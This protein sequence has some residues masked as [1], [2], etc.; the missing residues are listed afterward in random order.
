M[1]QEKRSTVK[2]FSSCC[3]GIRCRARPLLPG[4]TNILTPASGFHPGIISS[5]PSSSYIY[6]SIYTHTHIHTPAFPYGF[7]TEEHLSLSCTLHSS[8]VAQLNRPARVRL[9]ARCVTPPPLSPI[10]LFPFL[11]PFPSL[12]AEDLEGLASLEDR[13]T[14]RGADGCWEM[15][16]EFQRG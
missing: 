7:N 11:P 8:S 14:D 9:L 10:P 12:A 15:R 4:A 6:L 16:F 1:R 13:R 2:V 5:P 3:P